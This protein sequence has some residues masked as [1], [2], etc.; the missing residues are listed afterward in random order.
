MAISTLS[1]SQKHIS[2]QDSSIAEIS[3]ADSIEL[4]IIKMTPEVE[5]YIY[6]MDSIDANSL[7]LTGYRIQIFSA[8]GPDSKQTARKIQSE[9]IVKYPDI[10]SYTKW[11]NPSW[12]VRVGDFRTRLEALEIHQKLLET[13]PASYIL[14]DEINP[15]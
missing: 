15:K 10:N 14:V 13:F 6:M 7:K 4:L 9:F 11:S 5:K 2:F 1:Y 3:S 12:V 8:A